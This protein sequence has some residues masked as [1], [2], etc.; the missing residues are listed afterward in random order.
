[1]LVPLEKRSRR[2]I[3]L[4]IMATVTETVSR[5]QELEERIQSLEAERNSLLADISALKEKIA[6]F[7][8]E[9]TANTLEGEVESLKTEKA[10]LE[11]KAAGYEAETGYPL[12]PSV[13]EGYQA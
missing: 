7:E 12:P 6:N 10:V 8:L 2:D 1:M 5:K 11:E 13:E 4:T 9:K 3:V